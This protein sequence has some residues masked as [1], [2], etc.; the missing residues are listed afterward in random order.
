MLTK[1]VEN[2]TSSSSE[3]EVALRPNSPMLK[4]KIETIQAAQ[5]KSDSDKKFVEQLHRAI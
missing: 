1:F 3:E 5:S 2:L 4:N